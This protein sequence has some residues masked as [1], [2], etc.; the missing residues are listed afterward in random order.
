[1]QPGSKIKWLHEMRGGYGYREWVPGELV[2]V[3]AKT[4]RIRVTRK[5]GT[6]IERNVKPEHVK[7]AGGDVDG[8]E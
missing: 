1:M 6:P 3:N 5:D 7:L 4:L 2:K 8:V